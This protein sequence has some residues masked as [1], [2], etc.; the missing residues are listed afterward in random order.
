M[1]EDKQYLVSELG[2]HTYLNI[3]LG[4]ISQ[5]ISRRENS[6]TLNYLYII[7]IYSSSIIQFDTYSTQFVL[8]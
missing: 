4:A 2:L 1:I 7:I 8:I 5:A 6:N 3:G